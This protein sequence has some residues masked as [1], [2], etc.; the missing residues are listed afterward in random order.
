M[1]K[2]RV[3]EL[4]RKFN[5]SSKNIIQLLNSYGK[6]VNNQLSAVDEPEVKRITRDLEKSPQD[7]KE[8][9]PRTEGEKTE[10]RPR[11]PRPDG[12]ERPRRPRPEGEE[13]P[14]RPRPDGER[15]PRPA[16]EERPRRPRPEGEER[17]RRPRPDGE[18]RPRRPRP[19]GE[20]RPRRPRPDGD[21]PPRPEGEERP[22]RP[23]PDGE[24]RPRRPRP[25]GERPPRQDGERRPRPDG[26]RPPR[27]D[28]ERRPRP[29][30][31]RPPRQDG[32]RRPRPD[33][34]RRPRPD[35]ERRPRP[36]GDRPP[37]QD[38]DRRPRPTGDRPPR[39][40]GD[41]R[42]RPTGDRPPRQDGDRRPRPTGDR[43]P[44][45]D[46]DR[47]PRPDGSRPGYANRP[48]SGGR[49]P[50]RT[51]GKRPPFAGNKPVAGKK[52]DTK[53]GGEPSKD[54]R[55]Q[56][57]KKRTDAVKSKDKKDGDRKEN[58]QFLDRSDGQNRRKNTRG[59]GKKSIPKKVMPVTVV[60][61]VTDIT[62]SPE[63]TVR[64]MAEKLYKSN[65]EIIK[66]LMKK[67][68][69]VTAN[70]II[71]FDTAVY[72]GEQYNV[73]VEEYVEADIFEEAFAETPEDDSLRMERPPVVVVM[74]HVDHGKTS[75]LDAIRDSHVQEGE[76]GGIT[77]HI[78]AYTVEI[79][80]KPITFL[81]TPGHEAFTAMR[82][83]GAQITDIAILVVAAND[84]IMPQ[85][86]EAI[87]HAKAAEVEIIVA[88]NKVDL[89][90]ANPDRV[91]QE[92]TEHEL[93]V[94]EWG[95]ST[96]AVEVSAKQR[97]NI[98][99]LLEMIILAAEVK[100]L[101][102]NP[103]KK[104]RGSIIEAKLDKG[105]G[106]VA[107]VLVQDGTLREG[108]PVVAGSCY[109]RVRAMVDD[110]GKRVIEA[111][112]AIPIEI[113]GLSDV[114]TAG[115]MFYV[116]ASDKQARQLSGAVI[117]RGRESL[118]KATP[119]KVSLNDL[120][121]Q[122]QAGNVKDLNVVVK[123]D[124]HG[125]VE[126]LKASLEKL[127]NDEVR[128]RT[129]HGGV[130]AITETDV[131]LASASNAIIIGFNVRPDPLAR[132]VADSEKVDLRMYRVIYAAIEDIEAAMKGM[133]APVF[134]EKVLGHAEIR[135]LFKASGVGTIGGS[136]VLDGKITRNAQ[137]RI[138]RDGI[139]VYDGTLSTLRRFKDDVKDVASGYECGLLFH[140]F[141]DIKEG[142]KVEAYVME[143]IPHA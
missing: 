127:S 73:V 42:P 69:M 114:P 141:N 44:R 129:I 72:I 11:R 74:G 8:N 86:I 26:E 34:E 133:L 13:R 89:P 78:G 95:G 38:G 118:V 76:A 142:D 68:V 99:S 20:E 125:S 91:K 30:G 94:E 88:I 122:I 4:A 143:E 98:D 19:E 17:P 9:R 65:A 62:V 55:K 126:A 119:N 14:R 1:P 132:A 71:D 31:E 85:T 24:E 25:D 135:Q 139:I 106:P 103:N 105:R 58:R 5:T 48:A 79:N 18:E 29:D 100:E 28:G 7:A 23:R 93:L 35:G 137:V 22:R 80:N 75:L 113:V 33:G 39:Q 102:A 121:E 2:T 54:D 67:G 50:Q 120:F 21:R 112:P 63:V 117:A 96:I 52:P 46:G 124:V 128:V 43:P 108:D 16:G 131:M 47:R 15:P 70:Q 82:M 12:E 27:P 37:R 10:E 41:R 136:Y 61:T 57:W 64:E 83:R 45:Q 138:V 97:T 32:E 111:G 84:G 140:N 92:L 116:A 51:D 134:E 56:D 110:K 130:G 53:L 81:D 115:D 104:A 3:Y 107:T 6:E 60:P 49:P 109:G 40:D 77:Q 59:K 87:N 123:A 66:L 101:R 36:D 90:G